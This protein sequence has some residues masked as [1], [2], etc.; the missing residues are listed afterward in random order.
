MSIN[1][2]K[3]ATP[4]NLQQ[5]VPTRTGDPVD[6]LR[7]KIASR[8]FDAYCDSALRAELVRYG[9]S[10]LGL[11]PART[12]LVLDMELEAASCANEHRLIE[13]LDGLLRRFTDKD[14]KL[15]SKERSDAIQMV[16]RAKPGYSKGLAF[17]VAEKR[18]V[19][20]CRAN[21]VKVK[22]GLLRWDIP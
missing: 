9:V 21:R 7:L 22:V 16:C 6:A 12:A 5:P 13:E 17:D 8:V 20:F 14:K 15:D 1:L 4:P 10:D 11:D 3:P 18:V 2:N 19:D